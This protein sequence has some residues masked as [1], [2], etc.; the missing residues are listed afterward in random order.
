MQSPVRQFDF[1]FD[2]TSPYSYLAA[3]RVD[4]L[5]ERHGARARWVPVLLG[6]IFK[7]TQALP[8]TALHPWKAGYS[9]MDFGRSARLLDVSYRHPTVF[10][11]NTVSVARAFLWLQRTQP[12]AARAFALA[13]FAATFE[14]DQDIGRP[15]TLAAVATACGID[16]Q[17]MAAGIQD[18]EVKAMLVATNE[19]AAA[20]EVFGAPMCVLDGERFW[21]LDRLPHLDAALTEARA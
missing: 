20:K 18:P 8:L 7:H 14:H 12:R 1:F 4:A 21:G 13:A 3:H 11:Q 9:V 15:D 17:A 5:A 19:E 16:P 10:P 6:A 2:F